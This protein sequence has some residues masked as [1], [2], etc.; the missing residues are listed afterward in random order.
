MEN[1]EKREAKKPQKRGISAKTKDGSPLLVSRDGRTFKV[2]GAVAVV[3]A[4]F[5][6]SRT[7]EEVTQSIASGIDEDPIK[8][9]TELLRVTESLENLG[10]LEFG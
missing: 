8:L 10:L 3:W 5:D 2:S 9:R 1:M 6:G 4:M 7:V